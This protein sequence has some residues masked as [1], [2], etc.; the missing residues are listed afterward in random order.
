MRVTSYRQQWWLVL[1]LV[2]SHPFFFLCQKTITDTSLHSPL[3]P[4]EINELTQHFRA[5]D[6]D[7]NGSIDAD[8]LRTVVNNLGE[9]ISRVKL[10]ALINEVDIDG[11]QTIEFNEFLTLMVR[12]RSG[13]AKKMAWPKLLRRRRPSTKF[14]EPMTVH[15]MHSVKRRRKLFPNTL[16]FAWEKI[17][18]FK[19]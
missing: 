6:T 17:L 18:F 14:V 19:N 4:A 3:P 10:M 1:H 7:N 8:E 13:S 9:N 15:N 5:F 12:I 16:I 2:V 11:N